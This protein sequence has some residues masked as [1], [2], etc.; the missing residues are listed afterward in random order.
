M[1][2]AGAESRGVT[3][4]ENCVAILNNQRDRKANKKVPKKFLK[5]S[6]CTSVHLAEIFT[7]E[8]QK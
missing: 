8:V 7:P 2:L 3:R 1:R 6:S 4:N 5:S